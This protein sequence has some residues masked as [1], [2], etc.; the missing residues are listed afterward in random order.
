M[1]SGI[2]CFN[3]PL[4]HKNMAR[5]WPIWALYGLAWLFLVPMSLVLKV[6]R[7]GFS[8]ITARDTAAIVEMLPVGTLMASCFGVVCAMAVFQYLYNNRSACMIHSLPMDRNTLFV[9]NYLSGL[10]F[11]LLPNVCIFL[12]TLALEALYG[13]LNAQA[14]CTW[15][16]VQ[17]G[18]C[19]FFFSFASFCAMFT[20]HILALPAFYAI[21]NF[22]M[23]GLNSFLG[24]VMGGVLYG[25]SDIALPSP[26]VDWCT[27]V[28]QLYN[29]SMPVRTEAGYDGGSGYTSGIQQPRDVA[30]YVVVGLVLAVLGLMVYQRRH[31]ES[32]GDVVSVSWV[33]PIFKYGVALCAGLVFGSWTA[34]LLGFYERDKLPLSI[35]VCLWAA[36][37]YFVA[38]MLLRKSFRVLKSWKGA[39]ALVLVLAFGLAALSLDLFG[40]ERRVPQA[41][42]VQSVEVSGNFSS[43]PS[44]NASWFHRLEITDPAQI[45]KLTQLHQAIVDNRD[46]RDAAGDD[47]VDRKLTYTLKNGSTLRRN[48]TRVPVFKNE[49]EV[50]DSVTY[51]VQAL[52]DDRDFVRLMYEF[53]K[54]DTYRLMEAFMSNI[55]SYN[56]YGGYGRREIDLSS[57][58]RELWEAVKAD[59]GEGNI[60]VRY[61]FD[62]E[63]R[64]EN[65]C[66]ADLYFMFGAEEEKNAAV[67]PQAM[68]IHNMT[69]TLTPQAGHVRAVLEKAGVL[70]EYPD[71]FTPWSE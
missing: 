63:A 62:D 1:R 39:V 45:E 18:T 64:R 59:F 49:G 8:D 16:L 36:I 23:E 15:L 31:V 14:L 65:T 27:P 25:M 13:C 35:L 37:G 7:H 32:A 70:E 69:I 40:Y 44:D 50:P 12:I 17:S 61:L 20:G 47:Y 55:H 48:Y 26:L 46:R 4:F 54:Y 33:R 60:G 5:F 6:T 30:V 34:M 2:L 19:L 41:G 21:L 38:E 28:L 24:F 11:L 51:A 42:D 57:Y 29:A 56:E 71:L 67:G 9:T 3:R 68:N 22:L 58:A 52:L 10:T 43:Y 66:P 53:D